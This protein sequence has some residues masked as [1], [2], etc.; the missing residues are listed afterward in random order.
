MAQI[1]PFYLLDQA[2]A[3]D[4]RARTAERPIKADPQQI[5]LGP[6]AGQWIV[7]AHAYDDFPDLRRILDRHEVRQL[8]METLWPPVSV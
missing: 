7:S 5:A 1:Q 3:E 6:F 2:T 4:L 8:D